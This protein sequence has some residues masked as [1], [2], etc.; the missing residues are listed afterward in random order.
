MCFLKKEFCI[1]R[2][3]VIGITSILEK[4]ISEDRILTLTIIEKIA[5][6]FD[7]TRIEWLYGNQ[8]HFNKPILNTDDFISTFLKISFLIKFWKIFKRRS[9]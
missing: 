6:S 7:S 1:V 2:A 8:N 5:G 3:K 4:N 9:S